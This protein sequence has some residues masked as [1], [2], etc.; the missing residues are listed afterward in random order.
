MRV[1]RLPFPATPESQAWLVQS[2]PCDFRRLCH[3]G[4]QRGQCRE[5]DAPAEP[6]SLPGANQDAHLGRCLPLARL[7]Y[8]V[9]R[10][11]DVRCDEPLDL[12]VL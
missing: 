5:G 11:L 1:A 10:N 9:Y 4:Q 6:L 3:E 8:R 12:V 7:D 2:L